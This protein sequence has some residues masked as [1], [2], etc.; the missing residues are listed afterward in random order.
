[1]HGRGYE[2]SLFRSRPWPNTVFRLTK[3]QARKRKS[4]HLLPSPS[5]AHPTPHI[6]DCTYAWVHQSWTQIASVFLFSLIPSV[7]YYLVVYTYYRQT[8]DPHHPANL[9][10]TRTRTQRQRTQGAA[11]GVGAGR[12]GEQA[13]QAV[14][15]NVGYSRLAN[16]STTDVWID[17]GMTSSRLQAVPGPSQLSSRR[18]TTNAN[19]NAA[20][21]TSSSH[22]TKGIKRSRRPPPLIPSPSP[23][24]L[25]DTPGA[26]AY[27]CVPPR[28]RS[29]VYAAFAAPVGSAEYDKFV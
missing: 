4:L 14:Y 21:A 23:L 15:P 6:T 11:G 5:F 12:G 7:I 1:M 8:T 17:Q 20:A 10:H 18:Q 3:V 22:P 25:N 28:G 9:Q 24:G 26:P 16:P 29:R 2:K 13:S 19:A 27:E